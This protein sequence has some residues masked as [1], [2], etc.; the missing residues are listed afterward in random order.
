MGFR[1]GCAR[2]SGAFGNTVR[3]ERARR[4]VARIETAWKSEVAVAEKAVASY[5]RSKTWRFTKS[6]S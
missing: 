4:H 5:Y 6:R 3:L 2:G 1:A